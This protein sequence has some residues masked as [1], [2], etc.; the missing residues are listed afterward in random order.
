MRWSEVGK[1]RRSGLVEFHTHTHRRWDSMP[2]IRRPQDLLRADVLLSRERMKEMLEY[3][4]WHLCWP[5]GY[6]N[7]DYIK[8][9]KELGFS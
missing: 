6:Y 4:S 1:I 8:V 9:A 3:C 2:D 5:E 7:H